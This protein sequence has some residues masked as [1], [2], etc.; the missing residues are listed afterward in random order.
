MPEFRDTA[1]KIV[2]TIQRIA[3]LQGAT[4]EAHVLEQAKAQLIETGYDSWSGG[5]DFFTLV[6]ETP[7]SVYAAV[8]RSRET[9]EKTILKRAKDLTR[10]EAGVAITE[11]VIRPALVEPEAELTESPEGDSV[12][13]PS[14]W[15]EGYFRLFI[16][17]PHQAREGAH[18]LKRTL[19]SYQVAAF[20]AHDDIEPTKEWEAEVESALRTM[21][22]LAAVI[23]TDFVPSKWCDQEVGIAIGRGKLVIPLRAGADPHG[24]LAKY[25]GMNVKETPAREIADG[26]L[27][28]LAKH[29]LTLARMADALIERLACSYSWDSAKR[30]MTLLENLSELNSAQ[31]ARLLVIPEENSEV[32][33]AFG[34]PERIASLTSKI[35]RSYEA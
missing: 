12:T 8:E 1:R 21:D 18:Q 9:L 19:T 30:S 20:V 31:V 25:Q 32:K 17:H 28:I 34:V 24:F 23:T 35:G 7:I 15:T 26:I 10:T 14:F 13:V 27:A 33:E 2:A 6:L 29:P 5:T 22:A 16:T 11:V 3:T 4:E